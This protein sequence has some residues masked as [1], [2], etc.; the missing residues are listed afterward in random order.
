MNLDDKCV[1]YLDMFRDEQYQQLRDL[2]KQEDPHTVVTFC[3]YLARYEGQHH[4]MFLRQL[5]N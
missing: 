1:M 4:L 2:L 3:Y 5:M